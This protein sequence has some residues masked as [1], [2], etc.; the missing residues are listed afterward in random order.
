[1]GTVGSGSFI[2]REQR[3]RELDVL[4]AAM[5]WW[6]GKRPVGWDEA[7]HLD[8][9][10]VNT[11]SQREYGLAVMV[12]AYINRRSPDSGKRRAGMTD[13]DLLARIKEALGDATPGPW[14]VEGEDVVV[15]RDDRTIHYTVAEC[16]PSN[17]G[18]MALGHDGESDSRY[19]A[20]CSPDNIARLV[21]LAEYG[22]AANGVVEA[23]SALDFSDN[24]TWNEA[25]ESEVIRMPLTKRSWRSIRAALAALQ[26]VSK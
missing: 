2:P 16:D 6:E 24:T 3:L 14:S 7:R 5:H 13:L 8:N 15:L 26:E 25:M 4:N 10:T 1:M 9:A 19:I 17:E 18:T 21:A 23:M 11:S 12:A 22:V 20:R